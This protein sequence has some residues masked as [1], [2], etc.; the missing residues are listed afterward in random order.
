MGLLVELTWIA[1]LR[2][3]AKLGVILFPWPM[4]AVVLVLF[5][6]FKMTGPVRPEGKVIFPGLM[7][8]VARPLKGEWPN[9]V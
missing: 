5:E 9:C 1:E 2:Q 7:E 6:A 8:T 4:M 3:E